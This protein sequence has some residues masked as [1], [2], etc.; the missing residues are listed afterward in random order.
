MLNILLKNEYILKNAKK[1]NLP[2]RN[3]HNFDKYTI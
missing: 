3:K 1:N 2:E